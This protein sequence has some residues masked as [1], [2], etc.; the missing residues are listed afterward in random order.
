[1]EID[2]QT[3]NEYLNVADVDNSNFSGSGIKS[4]YMFRSIAERKI[5]KP[6]LMLEISNWSIIGQ[7]VRSFLFAYKLASQG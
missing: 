1:M 3:F 4:K 5:L 7:Q 6:V 2:I